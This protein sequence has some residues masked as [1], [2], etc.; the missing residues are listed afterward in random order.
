[1]GDD[2]EGDEGVVG[3]VR[4]HGREQMTRGEVRRSPKAEPVTRCAAAVVPVVA[5]AT[6]RSRRVEATSPAAG[7]NAAASEPSASPRQSASSKAAR[8]GEVHGESRRRGQPDANGTSGRTDSRERSQKV[9][10]GDQAEREA[11]ALSRS[12]RGF[13]PGDV[14]D[15]APAER[16]PPQRSAPRDHAGRPSERAYSADSFTPST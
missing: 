14:E 13:R 4:E 9:S 3:G 1:M 12:D 2:G 15:E 11:A 16:R 8:A 5:S 6:P 7:P 10:A